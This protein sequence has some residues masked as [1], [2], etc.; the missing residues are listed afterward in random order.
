MADGSIVF[1]TKIDNKE[2]TAGLKEAKEQIKKV[3]AEI[4]NERKYVDD[5]Y[6]QLEKTPND[7]GIQKNIRNHEDALQRLY[8]EWDMLEAKITQVGTKAPEGGEKAPERG[9][10]ASLGRLIEGMKGITKT[11][12]EKL[13]GLF[14]KEAKKTAAESDSLGK[15][16]FSLKNIFK[17]FA[18]GM[19]M[20]QLIN[21]GKEG[22]TNLL[23]YSD[24]VNKSLSGLSS[25]F[26]AF[27]NS[28]AAA[29]APLL[30][31]VAPV[32][33][34]I[35]D[36]CTAAANAIA[37]LF[38]MI[39]GKAT[40]T[41]AIK[42]NKDLAASYAG[43]G[44][45]AEEAKGQAAK[46]DEFNIVGQDKNAGGGGGGGVDVGSMFD[47]EAVG[48]T[49]ELAKR[50]KA[51]IDDIKAIAKTIAEKWKEA[52]EY[53]DNGKVI[54][55][56][57]RQI[58]WD[59]L[60]TIK[61]ITGATLEWAKN[62]DL[63]PLV[64]GIRDLLVALEPV[65][66]TIG[67]AIE[68]VWI[69]AILPIAKWILE[70][71]LPAFLEIIAGLLQILNPLLEVLGEA[72]AYV[73]ENF[74]K[75]FT[76][77]IGEGVVKILNTLA[78]WLKDIAKWIEKNRDFMGDVAKLLVTLI[79]G[80][81]SYKAIVTAVSAVVTAFGAVMSFIAA[82]PI[83]LVI[84]AITALIAIL[85]KAC[86]GW[87]EFKK[88]VVA[89]INTVVSALD[90]AGWHISDIIGN[91]KTVLNGLITFITGVFSGNWRQAW[92]GVKTIFKGVF[93]MLA[94][95]VKVALNAVIRS[96]NSLQFTA[97]DWVPGIGG[98]R[99][100]FNIPYLAS[101]AYVPPNAGEF[102]A[103]LGDNKREGEFVAPE[104]KLQEAVVNAMRMAGG[105]RDDEILSALNTLIAVVKAK[106]TGITKKQVGAAAVDYINEETVRTNS[107]PILV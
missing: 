103:V 82:N 93:D 10:K 64:T 66:D 19:I 26:G 12:A 69:H 18:G 44:A 2:L 41:K 23:R 86:G 27:K 107:S 73:F 34:K 59:I 45:A 1:D 43:V 91:L 83:V 57:L 28:I 6:K 102:M 13:L 65:I 100:G 25:S 72:I 98:Q 33:Q 30:N 75:P 61:V 35:I 15:S 104:S 3:E 32:L 48:E 85:V 38:A 62:L 4:R 105:S 11:G 42:Q 31:A 46:F 94:N 20:R 89:V 14:R 9:L 99:F 5:L 24:Q 96:V 53:N 87:E 40:Y 106:P 88:K 50:L 67:D 51:I 58:L 39:G 97:P 47:T 74:I 78:D 49:T 16:I 7:D 101:G 71:V 56:T 84:A 52:W 77:S 92:E 29:F 68:Y 70:G 60:D 21:W 81:A 36:Y 54:M 37:R 90:R 79:A 8:N 80:F 95:I 55:E 63:R 76:D 17:L 22:F